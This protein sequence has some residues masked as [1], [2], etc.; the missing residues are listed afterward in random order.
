MISRAISGVPRRFAAAL[1]IVRQRGWHEL[2]ALGLEKLHLAS[3]SYS[4]WIE[5]YDRLTPHQRYQIGREVGRLRHAPLISVVMP[6]AGI[7]PS[8]LSRAVNS[9]NRQLYPHWELCLVLEPGHAAEEA[10]LRAITDNEARVQCVLAAGSTLGQQLH[11]SMRHLRGQYVALMQPHDEVAE[12]A[13]YWI[14]KEIK[15]YPETD[16]IFSDE[17]RIDAEGR[18]HHAWFKSDWNPSLML[19][20]DAFA[21]LGV[22]R[23]TLL[24]Q[25]LSECNAESVRVAHDLVLHCAARAADQHIRHIPRVLYHVGISPPENAGAVEVPAPSQAALAHFLSQRGVAAT[26]SPAQG[27]GWQIEYPFPSSRPRVSILVPTTGDLSLLRPCLN[28]LLV[29]TAYSAVEVLLLI[30]ERDRL[31]VD[32]A[33]YIQ[34]LSDHPD[35]KVLTYAD[36]P[37]NYSWVNNWGVK[38]ASGEVI[39]FLNDDIEVISTDWLAQLVSRVWLSGVGVAGPLLLH[40]DDTIQHAGVILGL[41]G[42]AGHACSG[43]PEG[44]SG[45][46]GWA[47]L[48]RDVSCVTGACMVIRRSV[49]EAL[50]GFDESLAVAYNDVDLCI[51]V[52]Q[53]GWRIIW[54]PSARLWH[55]ESASLG[56][57]DAP[58]RAAKFAAEV[59]L[60][61]QRW[62]ALLDADP[63]YS[64]NLSLWRPFA[65]AF[66]PRVPPL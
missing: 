41:G 33:P 22:Y 24:E 1:R 39:C 25:V 8:A 7:L 14:A 30:S 12:H 28:S 61:R 34:E 2:L 19:R 54:T 37:F 66:P 11:A 63:Y 18:R 17:D 26:T 42:V 20:T 44:A 3:P 55:R 21:N 27:R 49:F 50:G 29:G 64:P 46:F 35:V 59:Q 52:R 6:A 48:E 5:K 16:L 51:R 36:R 38:Q 40:H 56:P 23:R 9:L 31:R 45:Y 58:A 4:R 47:S 32:R 57:H 65:L 15:T 53:G 13:F 10:A 60:M 62:G 43:E